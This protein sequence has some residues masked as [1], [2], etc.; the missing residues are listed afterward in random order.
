MKFAVI[1]AGPAGTYAARKLAEQGHDVRLFEDH[2]VCGSPV[3]CTGILTHVGHKLIDFNKK[4]IDNKIDSTA[5]FAPNG[6][7]VSVDFK[8]PNIIVNRT[9][10][11]QYLL[12]KA[13][14]A[15]ARALLGHKYISSKKKNGK[16][17]LI[18]VRNVKTKKEKEYKVDYLIGA[19]GPNSTVAKTNDMFGKREFF[20]GAQA[21]VKMKNDNN[22]LFYP[23]VK[24]LAWAVP[25][26]ENTMRIGI[27]SRDKAQ[28]RFKDF[29]KRFKGKVIAY[30]GGPIPVYQPNL[31]TQN[32]N[33]FL[34]G[35]A[36]TQV[37]ATTAGGIIQAMTAADSLAA[38]VEKNPD[39]PRYEKFWKKRMGRDLWA[40][41]MMRKALDRFNYDDW[42]KLIGQF[43][44]DSL[45]NI[46][47]E[48]DR[49]QGMKIAMK[50]FARKP[51]L[52]LWVRKLL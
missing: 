41:L 40:H 14:K 37:K 45:N 8:K 10:Y 49:D 13:E 4:F 36:A 18:T 51:G 31:K 3:Q 34:L 39:S 29:L 23:Y 9:K 12:D 19:D 47:A 42:N 35:D 16:V 43:S 5:I 30:Q 25:E 32:D 6:S 50:C 52:L 33:V 11:D 48:E 7:F 20:M 46:L 38:A 17:S 26:D 21:T 2:L 44:K 28:Q 22:I 27:A 15:G 24:D 1:G